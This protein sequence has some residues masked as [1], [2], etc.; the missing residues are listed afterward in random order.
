MAGRVL[1]LLVLKIF[2]GWTSLYDK[3]DKCCSNLEIFVIKKK[4]KHPEQWKLITISVNTCWESKEQ[5]EKRIKK[6]LVLLSDSKIILNFLPFFFFFIVFRGLQ[7]QRKIYADF[8]HNKYTQL[9]LQ[10]TVTTMNPRCSWT[11]V[12]AP[13][14][15]HSRMQHG[16]DVMWSHS[17]GM[18]V[19]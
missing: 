18:S 12:T 6:A 19:L 3:S 5:K 10:S 7:G 8:I 17:G 4:A 1:F 16:T 14:N 2:V 9:S 15:T 13:E 11:K